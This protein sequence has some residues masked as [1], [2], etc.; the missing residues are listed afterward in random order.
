[1]KI[2]FNSNIAE[3]RVFNKARYSNSLWYGTG[4]RKIGRRLGIFPV[5][6]KA[7]AIFYKWD[8]DYWAR[9]LT[10]T[11]RS[12]VPFLIRLMARSITSLIVRFT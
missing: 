7:D 12:V 8:N 4:K 11:L 10:T 3:V 5:Y 6:E 1:M 2:L 9:S